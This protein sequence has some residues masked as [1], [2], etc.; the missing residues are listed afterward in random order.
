MDDDIFTRLKKPAL[1]LA[2]PGTGKTTTLIKKLANLIND[3]N[4]TNEEI[5]III[6][7]FTRKAT[8]EIKLRLYSEISVNKLKKIDLLV[9]TIHSICYEL[10]TRYSNNDYNNYEVLPEDSQ[11][12]FIYS[13]LDNLGFSTSD[14]KNKWLLSE[15]LASIF[16]KITDE[17]ININGI[18]YKDN[19][20]L[21]DYCMVYPTYKRILNNRRLFDFATI[22]ETLLNELAK[23]QDFSEKVKKH[24]KYFLVDEYQ[25]VNDIQD[26]IFK[27][28]SAVDNNITVVGDDDQSIY[29]FRSSNISNIYQF[30]SGF[31]DQDILCKK[32]L[33]DINYRSTTN[34]IDV[35]KYVISKAEYKR[36]KK[37]INGFRNEIGHKPV[38]LTFETDIEEAEFIGKSILNLLELKIIKKYSDVS[39]LFRSVKGHSSAV[40]NCLTSMNIP[41]KQFGAGALFES[42]LGLE[43]IALIDLYLAKDMEKLSIFCEKLDEIDTLKKS[44]LLNKYVDNKYIDKL[45]NLFNNKKYYSCIDLTYDIFNT[46]EIFKRYADIGENLGKITSIVLSFDDFSNYYNPYGLFGYL[47]YLKNSQ[48]VDNDE[49]EQSNAVNIMTIHQAKGLEF[50]IVF[51]PSQNERNSKRSLLDKFDEMLNR[52]LNKSKYEERRIFYVGSTRAEEL[53]VISHSK[54]LQNKSKTYNPNKYYIELLQYPN[55]SHKIDYEFLQKQKFR[56]KENHINN[57]IVLSYNKIKLYTICPLA[58]KY[59]HFWNLKTARI[60]GLEFGSNVHAI[61]EKILKKMKQGLQITEKN[62]SEIIEDNW[63]NSNFRSKIENENYKNAAKTQIITFVKN[64]S[65]LLQTNKIFSI[66]DEFNILIDDDL[67]T[68]RMDAVFESEKDITI[69]DFKTGDKKDY[70]SQL[71]FYSVCFQSKYNKKCNNLAVYYLK[72]GELDYIKPIKAEKEIDLIKSVSRKIKSKAFNPNPGKHCSNCS[73]NNICEYS[74]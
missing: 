2:G 11:V 16:N 18:N 10:L 70:T 8:E 55:I 40:S 4:E 31:L 65:K 19:E 26:K 74:A 22:Q 53:L 32:Y 9:G 25:D 66:E 1:I 34:I 42:I 62:V 41:F 61:I 12:H 5:G 15:E 24:F 72:S 30:Q 39:I 6:S 56:E 52:D 71:A 36:E 46:T 21:E 43:F 50:P 63:R 58:Y 60:G 54:H 57:N 59:S 17:Q 67:I 7:T 3:L 73:F 51:I 29:G 23:D 45:E 27:A 49:S 28:L 33:L 35:S 13:I 47:L 37:E 69:L 38:L 64:I 48:K 20:V 14:I 44:N 68:G